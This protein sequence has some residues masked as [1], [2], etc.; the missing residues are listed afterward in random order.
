L[1]GRALVEFIADNLVLQ[2]ALEGGSAISG[3]ALKA[4]AIEPQISRL[5]PAPGTLARTQ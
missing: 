2:S 4:G 1:G 5:K 3:A